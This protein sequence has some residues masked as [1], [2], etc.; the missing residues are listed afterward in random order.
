MLQV[1][2]ERITAFDWRNGSLVDT[3]LGSLFSNTRHGGVWRE[4]RYMGR[5]QAVYRLG[6]ELSVVV[7]ETS[8]QARS[9]KGQMQA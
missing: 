6:C 7:K 9:D 3:G 5:M 2:L 4:D 8:F 1:L